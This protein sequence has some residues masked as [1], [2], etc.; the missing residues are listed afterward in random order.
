MKCTL[1]LVDVQNASYYLF[2]QAK[3]FLG[4]CQFV[5]SVPILFRYPSLS[6]A[7]DERYLIAI[8]LPLSFV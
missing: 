8:K 1:E 4:F 5:L 2:L 3:P 6:L 7:L